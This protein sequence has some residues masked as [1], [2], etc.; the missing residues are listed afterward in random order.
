V[1]AGG[2]L[3]THNTK[4]LTHALNRVRVSGF[5]RMETGCEIMYDIWKKQ[6]RWKMPKKPESLTALC[7]RFVTL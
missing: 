1:L 6:Q 3:E 2:R 4:N 5:R 7:N